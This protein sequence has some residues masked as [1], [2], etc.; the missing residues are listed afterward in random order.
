MVLLESLESRKRT[1]WM[2][3]MVFNEIVTFPPDQFWV[4]K[5]SCG[6]SAEDGWG[7]APTP[8]APSTVYASFLTTV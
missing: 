6:G 8:P 1:P 4:E 5:H 7:R 3:Q 2:L